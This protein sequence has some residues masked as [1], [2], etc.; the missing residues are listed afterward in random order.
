M[1]ISTV[2]Y[3]F[4]DIDKLILELHTRNTGN[5]RNTRNNTK[6]SI[7]NAGCFDISDAYKPEEVIIHNFANNKSPGGP[8]SRF[9]FEGQFISN[10]SWSNTQEDQIIRLYKNNIL[11][12]HS[13]YPICKDNMPGSEALLYSKCGSMLCD[14]ITIAALQDPNYLKISNRYTMINRIKLILAVCAKYNKILITGLWGCG[15]FGGKPENL[16]QLWKEALSDNLIPKPSEIIFAIKIDGASSKWGTF[17]DVKKLF[18]NL[19]DQQISN[20][21]I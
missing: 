8:C 12:P 13:L 20:Y 9:S 16:S 11:L 2:K 21:Q 7:I 6:I 17:D 4:S 10:E 5:T 15:A 18:T 3:Y 1:A 14:V 19:T